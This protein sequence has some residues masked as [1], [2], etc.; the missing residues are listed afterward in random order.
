MRSSV[1]TAQA[2]KMG[3]NGTWESPKAR[4]YLHDG[5]E[6]SVLAGVL[7]HDEAF[8]DQA[9]RLRA[10][11]DLHKRQR[12][13]DKIAARYVPY[14]G[15]NGGRDAV[16][17]LL[18]AAAGP[19][20]SWWSDP[21]RL[22]AAVVELMLNKA[23][24]LS[25]G[26]AAVWPKAA[27]DDLDARRRR[28]RRATLEEGARLVALRGARRCFQCGARLRSADRRLRTDYCAPHDYGGEN[29]VAERRRRSRELAIRDVLDAAS[30][31]RRTRRAQ[32][33][34]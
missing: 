25:V 19:V 28:N 33:R 34:H 18:L 16:V 9:A 17:R 30:G 29:A 10:V 2:A 24:V 12:Q 26:L 3:D 32:K 6:A 22:P 31:H 14:R 23:Q 1:G 27:R 11:A 8:R 15:R 7:A 13:A 5:E 20:P 4:S 21:H